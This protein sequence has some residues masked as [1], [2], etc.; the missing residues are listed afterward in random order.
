MEE[1]KPDLEI[2]KKKPTYTKFEAAYGKLRNAERDL[3]EHNYYTSKYDA[4]RNEL[5]DNIPQ[6][7]QYSNYQYDDKPFKE[8]QANMKHP[9]P[10]NIKYDATTKPNANGHNF[11]PNKDTLK[12]YPKSEYAIRY[13]ALADEIADQDKS[14]EADKQVEAGGYTEEHYIDEDGDEVD[15]DD[16]NGMNDEEA[17]N[18]F[19]DELDSK[20]YKISKELYWSS[21]GSMAVDLMKKGPNPV[22]PI[23]HQDGKL[24]PPKKRSQINVVD[25]LNSLKGND[26][27][28]QTV[29]T[30]LSKYYKYVNDDDHW[31]NPNVV[32][33]DET[34]KEGNK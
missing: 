9:Y 34:N 31:V 18:H 24:I 20:P 1:Q 17:Y 30:P 33:L 5:W 19:K 12:P 2:V 29:N 6:E 26:N 13:K 25:S 23:M 16:E 22:G 4:G 21:P 8:I 14:N 10:T 3:L 15:E 28:E 27:F 32:D 7:K 11:I